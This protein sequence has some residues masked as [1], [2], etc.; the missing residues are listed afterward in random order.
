[1]QNTDTPSVNLSP[2]LKRLRKFVIIMGIVL[3]IMFLTLFGAVIYK[4]IPK[5]LKTNPET[6][7]TTQI[8]RFMPD[9]NLE[10]IANASTIKTATVSENML[11]LLLDN[12]SVN[13]AKL[14]VLKQ[15][16]PRTNTQVVIIDLCSG[17]KLSQ[18]NLK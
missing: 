6:I 5:K 7:R 9:I 18:I 17:E 15:A 4:L 3:C 14:N 10:H 8:C 12:N 13:E 1:M 16:A 2:G 11:V